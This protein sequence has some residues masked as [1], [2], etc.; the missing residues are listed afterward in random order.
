[1]S[2]STRLSK[3]SSCKGLCSVAVLGGLLVGSIPHEA[4]AFGFDNVARKAEELAQQGYRAPET[5]LPDELRELSYTEYS[6]IQFKRDRDVWSGKGAP[7]TL[8]F[9]H[10]GMHY[11]SA[12]QLNSVDQEGGVHGF[13]YNP[14]DF[15]Y[16][17]L[18]ISEAVKNS[19]GL[20]IA[21]VRIN[22]ALNEGDR[23][24]EVM[25]F[26]GASY[27]RAIGEGQVY[28]LSGRGLAVD[29]GLPSGEE[30]PR[31]TEMWIVEPGPESQYLTIFALLDSPSVAG[32]YRFV[33][34]PGDDTLVDVQSRLYL[35]RAVEKLGIAPLTSMYLYGPEQPSSTQHYIP[36]IHDSNG[37]LINDA[38]NGWLWR[39]LANPARLM[40]NRHATPQLRGYGLMQRGHNFSDYQDIAARYD[41]RPSAWVE[42]QNEWGA[43]SVE[44]IQIPTDNE[45]ND[46]IVSMWLSDEPHEPGKPLA[47]D[48]RITFTTNESRHLD[49]QLAWVEETRRSRGEVM[50]DN[51]VREPDGTLA[52]VL[53]FIGPSLSGIGSDANMT[54]EASVGDNGELAT[55]RVVHNPAT[56]GWRVF[57]NVKRNNGSQ[58]LDIRAKLMLDGK[59]MSETW[60]YRLPANG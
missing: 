42:P 7:F 56:N 28:G 37:L 60:Y 8:S 54:V 25:V 49:P 33:L 32:A 46:N 23:K 58:P 18:G 5:S 51:L 57:V 34:R 26:L 22:H 19:D 43:G 50:R 21:G 53:D 15:T 29:T 39:P 20:G 41:L 1:M 27:F 44:L 12:I 59:Q 16:G 36:A 35:R 17:D 9:I 11:D 13:A 2:G 38:Q 52:F 3:F 45:T 10:E 30:F 31:F 48:Y 6:Q 55:S 14:D 47:F 24:D 4:F 40:M